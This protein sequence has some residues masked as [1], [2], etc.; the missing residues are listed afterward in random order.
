MTKF[1]N[2]IFNRPIDYEL[3]KPSA[4]GADISRK[5]EMATRILTR[6]HLQEQKT[7]EYRHETD[8]S[9]S[10]DLKQI[11]QSIKQ[12]QQRVLDKLKKRKAYS[13]DRDSSVFIALYPARLLPNDA[14]EATEFQ[15]KVIETLLQAS[16]QQST[17]PEYSHKYRYAFE[18]HGW[19]VGATQPS[20]QAKNRL[21]KP[22]LGPIFKHQVYRQTSDTDRINLSNSMIGQLMPQAECEFV[23]R[24][25]RA[26]AARQPNQEPYTREQVAE[27][28]GE[29]IPAMEL[30]GSRIEDIGLGS[31]AVGSSKVVDVSDKEFFLRI[32]DCGSHL[33]LLLGPHSIENPTLD[34][35]DSLHAARVEF[36][37]NEDEEVIH[38][39]GNNV[40]EG[41][42]NA[43]S[44]IGPLDTKTWAINEITAHV[45][46]G[47]R[48]QDVP[49]GMVISS[50][51]MTGKS[52]PIDNGD[53]IVASFTGVPTFD[54]MT[55]RVCAEF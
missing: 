49:A 1:V 4:L 52:R 16:E 32:A 34:D 38:G 15:T 3:V 35:L 11:E 51:T 41:Q 27:C 21:E 10:G 33:A 42:I 18:L 29:V 9:K 50:G 37:M 19:K 24:F 26:L 23:F 44:V 40:Y 30:V 7:S 45:S 8:D 48:G 25:K 6:P 13:T 43:S 14:R 28:I 12:V 17:D 20:V 39:R 54:G 36:N 46:E 22:F 31:A 55:V 2:P 47:G 53:Q 5:T